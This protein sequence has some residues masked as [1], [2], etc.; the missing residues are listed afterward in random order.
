MHWY[1]TVEGSILEQGDILP[2][3]TTTRAVA[4]A[5]S[6]AGYQI[7]VGKGNY[8]VLSQ[9]CDL[10]NDKI[11]EVLLADVITYRDL[12]AEAPDMARSSNF[13]N[14]LIQGGNFAYFLLPKF[15]GPLQLDWSVV[16]FHQLMI[17]DLAS[18]RDLG[19]EVGPSASVDLAL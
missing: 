2:G 10:E 17:I 4:D 13:K 5:E 7:R 19:C 11:T 8:V 9:S 18:C 6:P 14:A 12:V 16:N 3:L 1:S 15:S